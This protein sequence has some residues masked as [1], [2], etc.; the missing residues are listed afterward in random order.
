MARQRLIRC[1]I[2]RA[3]DAIHGTCREQTCGIMISGPS[4]N[5]EQMQSFAQV[6]EYLILTC[7]VTVFLVGLFCYR[8][9]FTERLLDIASQY[10]DVRVKLLTYYPDYV[11]QEELEAEFVPPFDEVENPSVGL[12]RIGAKI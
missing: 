5:E 11:K 10:K 8:A 6:V 3:R 4:L 2:E 7:D 12:Q 9:P 1:A